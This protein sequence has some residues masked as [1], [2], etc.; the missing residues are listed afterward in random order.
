[1]LWAAGRM[2]EGIKSSDLSRVCND[3]NIKFTVSASQ[4]LFLFNFPDEIH[5]NFEQSSSICR[6]WED[7]T[8]NITCLIISTTDG[9]Q[10]LF[11][12]AFNYRSSTSNLH[13]PAYLYFVFVFIFL[14]YIHNGWTSISIHFL[15]STLHYRSTTWNFLSE[16]I[17]TGEFIDPTTVQQCLVAPL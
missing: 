17:C 2:W 4:L 12:A 8:L 14:Y 13:A 9:T 15:L 7:P 6:I 11:V 5:F 16:F 10:S 1:M 3:V